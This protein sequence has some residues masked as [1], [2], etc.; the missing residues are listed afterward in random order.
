MDCPIKFIVM[1]EWLSSNNTVFRDIL[2][3]LLY[4]DYVKISIESI[5]WWTERE[6][7]EKSVIVYTL[8]GLSTTDSFIF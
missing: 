8:V 1:Q 6:I 3:V 4:S 5:D 7:R 2:Y